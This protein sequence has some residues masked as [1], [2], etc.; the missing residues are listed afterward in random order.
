MITPFLSFLCILF[1]FKFS[2]D[3]VM[4]RIF[5]SIDTDPKSYRNTYP[6][7]SQINSLIDD[8]HE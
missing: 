3:F 7:S 8:S 6:L 2:H 5:K 4:S 1:F